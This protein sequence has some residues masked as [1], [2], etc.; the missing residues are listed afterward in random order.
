MEL[1][2]DLALRLPSR[3]ERRPKAL[4]DKLGKYLIKM[5]KR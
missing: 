2:V 1:T 5:L 4:R 3:K